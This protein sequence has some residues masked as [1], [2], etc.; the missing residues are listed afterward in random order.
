M[1]IDMGVTERK[2]NDEDP[3]AKIRTTYKT[4]SGTYTYRAD[5][6]TKK[7]AGPEPE[8]QDTGYS[9]DPGVTNPEP[10]YDEPVSEPTQEVVKVEEPNYDS[11]DTTTD[12]TTGESW[13][14][15]K[16]TEADN[17]AKETEPVVYTGGSLGTTAKGTG[18]TTT[19]NSGTSTTQSISSELY[20]TEDWKVK[21]AADK[22]ANARSGER[23]E[24]GLYYKTSGGGAYTTGFGGTMGGGEPAFPVQMA[25]NTGL[26]N[27]Q[28]AANSIAYADKMN[29]YRDGSVGGQRYDARLAGQGKST[30][31]GTTGA[32]TPTTGTGNGTTTTGATTPGVQGTTTVNGMT[33]A[34][35][36][37]WIAKE[38]ERL[39][40]EGRGSLPD[41]MPATIPSSEEL[42]E[43]ARERER[44]E[45][46]NSTFVYEPPQVY[47]DSY[48][49]PQ[50]WWTATGGFTEP[51][52]YYDSQKGEHVKMVP[53]G[54]GGY[55][56][57]TS[58][59][60]STVTRDAKT[61]LLENSTPDW[62]LDQS[63]R[64]YVPNTRI[65]SNTGSA[66]GSTGTT[67][68]KGSTTSTTTAGST[69]ANGSTTKGN[70]TGTTTT[71]TTSSGNTTTTGAGKTPSQIAREDAA[72]T[73]T[74]AGTG[75]TTGGTKTPSQ[76]N[77]EDAVATNT[78]T[79][80][81]EST[82]PPSGST[83]FT[84][85]YGQDMEKGVKAPYRTEGYTEEELNAYGNKPRSDWKYY[86]GK[87]AYEGYYL[88]PNGK[89]Y[90]VDQTKYE[91]WKRNGGSYKGWEEG[92]RDYWNNF[93]TFY[94]YNKRKTSYGGG[95][96]GYRYYGGN[97]YSYS[98]SGSSGS[99][100]EGN[101]IYWNTNT[102]WSI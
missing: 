3:R 91:Y 60:A 56:V 12:T 96:G 42:K 46:A 69:T 70:S 36:E 38:N 72:A 58:P 76:I 84:P 89:Y 31:T 78:G 88:A 92:M 63:Y 100:N 21:A 35:A 48:K 52:E 64:V 1:A 62:K 18:T 25:G 15:E 50:D 99:S 6:G 93:G 16:K 55:D 83:Y 74:A 82:K 34:E 51:F 24:S 57:Y 73:K 59:V 66:T 8:V 45:A 30:T 85:S 94:G 32:T 44:E 75:S 10:S 49:T 37:A 17:K 29:N 5:E 19:A 77:R 54:K 11:K 61:G 95:G 14:D 33:Q 26:T 28:I 65:G 71:G 86:N 102:S 27:Y 22:E 101:G 39:A 68:G 90:P 98:G 9:Y 7:V 79:T 2:R 43:K 20:G 13:Q 40:A 47:S 67:A 23:R 97:G 87:V 81:T 53:D 4:D 80:G 41:V